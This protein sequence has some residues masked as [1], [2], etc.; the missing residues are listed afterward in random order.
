MS[1]ER[2]DCAEVDAKYE[3]LRAEYAE[4][5]ARRD[6]LL[7]EQARLRAEEAEL[8]RSL[9]KIRARLSELGGNRGTID[10]VARAMDRLDESIALLDPQRTRVRVRSTYADPSRLSE[11]PWRLAVVASNGPKQA[12]VV[13]ISG[14]RER[15]TFPHPSTYGHTEIH[16][17]DRHLLLCLRSTP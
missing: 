9:A 12:R 16:P 17:D 3:H 1:Q 4:H 8:T 6:A 10:S 13:V 2:P 11:Q 15:L 7:A 5:A 14:A